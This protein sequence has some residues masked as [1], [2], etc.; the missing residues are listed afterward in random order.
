M[1][2]PSK[3]RKQETGP[4]PR[5]LAHQ[6]LCD[7]SS[8]QGAKSVHDSTELETRPRVE[9]Q[10]ASGTQ[11]DGIMSELRYVKIDL[12]QVGELVGVLLR[13][14]MCAETK[15]EI[16]AKGLDRME[17]ERDEEEK[18]EC[19]AN[20]EGSSDESVDGREGDRRQVVCRWGPWLR[21]TS[22]R[23]NHFHPRQ[24]GARG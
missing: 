3:R 8:D 23:R 15:A 13:R 1:G 16:A 5:I 2:P 20:L 7:D 9:R 18:A 22:D 19:K 10:G 12:S 11:S 6:S 24:R 4:D 14:E 21:K 17:K